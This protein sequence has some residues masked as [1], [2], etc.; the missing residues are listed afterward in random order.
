LL[1][2]GLKGDNYCGVIE[3]GRGLEVRKTRHPGRGDVRLAAAVAVLRW[4]E[5]EEGEG[6]FWSLR[7]FE[8]EAA[9]G[10]GTTD[11]RSARPR[12]RAGTAERL[13]PSEERGSGQLK[14]N[15]WA[16]A[17]PAGRW[18]DWAKRE[19]VFGLDFKWALSNKI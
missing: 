2:L 10:Q 17:G 19:E 4:W 13:K 18:A 7:F 8:W 11:V 6:G 9:I 14:K 12:G 15:E 5:E 16:A 1:K 3:E